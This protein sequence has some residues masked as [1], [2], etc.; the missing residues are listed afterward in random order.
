M[1]HDL[2]IAR[3]LELQS[4]A[5]TWRNHWG[6]LLTFAI[7]VEVAIDTFWRDRP[8]IFS[9]T[10]RE[11]F[12]EKKILVIFAVGVMVVV[13]LNR[14]SFHGTIADEKAD[15][16]QRIQQARIAE[17]QER[18][19][20][21]S[22]RTWLF[23]DDVAEAVRKLAISAR[24]QKAVVFVDRQFADDRDEIVAFA[25]KFD[26]VLSW[27][28][29]SDSFGRPI[30]YPAGGVGI[31]SNIEL[32]PSWTT[33]HITKGVVLETDVTASPRTKELAIGLAKILNDSQILATPFTN[34]SLGPLNLPS[35]TIVI[36]VGRRP[37]SRVF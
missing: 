30:S 24:G 10:W 20:K 9:P 5:R 2:E 14:E 11:H 3:A 12:F 22:P 36:I 37:V 32:D 15:D 26:N 16:I 23:T 4:I 17:L 29:W 27:A 25:L 13:S 34:V 28:S 19:I 1:N 21:I 18:L 8:R 35:D 6:A 33:T 31:L 7:L